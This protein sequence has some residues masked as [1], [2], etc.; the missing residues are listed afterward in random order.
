[1]GD[2]DTPASRG[3]FAAEPASIGDGTALTGGAGLASTTRFGAGEQLASATATTLL[4]KR[5]RWR[6]VQ[7][8]GLGFIGARSKK[9]AYYS[10][11]AFLGA[12]C[13]AK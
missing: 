6:W 12:I 10:V 7:H 2:S 1:M 9:T 8:W 5:A 4:R 13:A 11:A 3:V